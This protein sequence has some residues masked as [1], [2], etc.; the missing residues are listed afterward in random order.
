MLP[1]STSN[2]PPPGSDAVPTS[3]FGLGQ[4]ALWLGVL[5]YGESANTEEGAATT[6]EQA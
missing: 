6:G 5:A 2:G 4:T 3:L 1:P